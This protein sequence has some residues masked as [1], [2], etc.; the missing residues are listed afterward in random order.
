MKKAFGMFLALCMILSLMLGGTTALAADDGY[1]TGNS[2]TF[3]VE[4]AVERTLAYQECQNLA[5]AHEFYHTA[6]DHQGELDNCWVTEDP[7]KETMS[8]TNNTQFMYG[9]DNVWEFYCGT[10]L[11]G[12]GESTQAQAMAVDTTGQITM[13]EEWYAAGTLWY[14]MLMSPVIEVAKDGQT[15]VGLWQSFGTVTE[16]SMCQWTCEDYTM[17]F[18]K[19]SDGEWRIWHLRTFVHF[20]TTYGYN[21][22]EQNMATQGTGGTNQPAGVGVLVDSASGEPSGSGDMPQAGNEGY[23]ITGTYYVGLDL[24][25]VPVLATIPQPYDTWADI[26]DTFAWGG[27]QPL[28]GNNAL[29]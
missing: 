7:Y 3:T 27:F 2:G 26:E 24:Y 14:H 15:A 13:D 12:H 19:Q 1:V 21:W 6:L 8:W 20:Y 29:H 4:D 11:T 18:V 10:S 25:K 16:V 28:L 9:Y 23:S 17:V 22:Y 5:G